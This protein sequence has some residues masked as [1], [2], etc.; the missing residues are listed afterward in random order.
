MCAT[1]AETSRERGREMDGWREGEGGRERE[2]E[3]M[4]RA[5]DATSELQL[6]CNVG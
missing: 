1:P 5:E 6:C 2:G 3:T 4:M